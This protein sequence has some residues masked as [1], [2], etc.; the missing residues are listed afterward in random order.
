[1][2]GLPE[3]PVH[4]GSIYHGSLAPCIS[5]CLVAVQ[6]EKETL[7]LIINILRWSFSAG[8]S[9]LASETKQVSYVRRTLVFQK[10]P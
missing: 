4:L 2:F 1:M 3:S 7:E 9:Q 6:K 8:P 5:S 10:Q